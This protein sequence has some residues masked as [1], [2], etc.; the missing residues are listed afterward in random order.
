MTRRAPIGWMIC[1]NRTINECINSANVIRVPQG[2]VV[3]NTKASR[4][5]RFLVPQAIATLA[6]L[7]GYGAAPAFAQ[8]QAVNPVKDY[9]TVLRVMN[10]HL[11][12]WQRRKYAASVLANA[13]RTR[14][15]P[16]FIMAI[17]TV[18]SSWRSNAVSR[19]GARGLGQLM[20]GTAA[21]LAVN[22]RDA[23]ENLRGTANY[24][25]SLLDRFR[26]QQNWFEK[27][28][29]GYNAGPNAVKRYGGIPPFAETQRYVVKVLRVYRQLYGKVGIAWTPYV[30]HRR[31][32][33]RRVAREEPSA[34]SDAARLAESSATPELAIDAF[35][36]APIP[37]FK[38]S[39]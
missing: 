2:P 3:V 24:L 21:R 16:R 13:Q 32:E 36:L 11:P 30:S 9:A 1:I 5:H 29:A 12:D 38:S 7:F 35:V 18:E 27:A 4:M 10:P 17:V 14:V 6:L 33:V 37:A 8:G 22:A 31:D 39:F 28:I 34:L 23:A 20:P 15:D 19:T 25:K 26:G